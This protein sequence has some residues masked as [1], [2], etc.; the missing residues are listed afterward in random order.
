[1]GGSIDRR[2]I[3]FRGFR[4]KHEGVRRL[5][6]TGLDRRLQLCSAGS[7][8]L[9]RQRFRLAFA[10]AIAGLAAAAGALPGASA[11]TAGN[12]VEAAAAGQPLFRLRLD[13]I[14][15]PVAGQV[16]RDALAEADAA[17]SA[18]LVIELS[19]PGGLLST[20]R[21]IS[22]AM[23]AAKTPVVVW[24]APAGSQAASAGF[25]ILLSAD[26]AAMAPGTN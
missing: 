21:E 22:T 14:V 15:H 4:V 8:P 7:M 23:L 10:A 5:A 12:G 20:T 9:S 3:S 18:G 25:F 26:F 17:G 13:S 1:M 24:V 2:M 11:E 6:G 19:T 16:V